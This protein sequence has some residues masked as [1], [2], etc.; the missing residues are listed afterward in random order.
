[1]FLDVVSVATNG[2]LAQKIGYNI[3]SEFNH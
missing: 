1:M 2:I 3:R